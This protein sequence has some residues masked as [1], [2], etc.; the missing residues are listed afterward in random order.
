M[1][2]KEGERGTHGH[3]SSAVEGSRRREKVFLMV[4]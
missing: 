2:E 1:G 3:R 4:F